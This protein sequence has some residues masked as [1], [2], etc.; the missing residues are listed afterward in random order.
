MTEVLILF[1]NGRFYRSI[2]SSENLDYG[3]LLQH[4][5]KNKNDLSQ[6]RGVSSGY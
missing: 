5:R 3:L 6:F 1:Y 2:E 4:L